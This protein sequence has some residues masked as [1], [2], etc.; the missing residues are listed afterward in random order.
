[1]WIAIL[2]ALTG[3]APLQGRTVAGLLLSTS[4]GIG[5]LG[6]LQMPSI[7]A[8]GSLAFLVVFG[9]IAAFSAYYWLLDRFPATLVATHT[10]V[11]PAVA[12]VLGWALGG[13]A[14]S[15]SLIVG[16]AIIT[17]AIAL[18]GFSEARPKPDPA[19]TTSRDRFRR[20]GD[21]SA[22]G[23]PGKVADRYASR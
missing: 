9:S 19:V 11:N 15:M 21:I 22:P 20:S 17:G 14:V 2:L 8:L 18:V 7:R 6:H 4:A 12:V 3:G 10:Y 13:E 1:V 5:E 16:L 23:I